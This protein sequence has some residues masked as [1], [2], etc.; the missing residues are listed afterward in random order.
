MT[1]SEQQLQWAV[2]S[3]ALP[4]E[5]QRELFPAFVVVADEL[6]LDFDHWFRV[7]AGEIGDSWNPDQRDRLA[8]LDSLLEAMSGP[9]NPELR[10]GEESLYQERWG[11]VRALALAALSAFG[12]P[13]GLPPTDRAVYVRG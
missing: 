4:A 13:S 7:A 5:L 12:W 10:L 3:L 8:A 6:A 2:Q 11:E 9:G 1:G